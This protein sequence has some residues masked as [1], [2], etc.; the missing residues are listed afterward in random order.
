MKKPALKKEEFE[1]ELQELRNNQS[2]EEDEEEDGL[3]KPSSQVIDI[4]DDEVYDAEEEDELENLADTSGLLDPKISDKQKH[5]SRKQQLQQQKMQLYRQNRT[6]FILFIALCIGI[7]IIFLAFFLLWPRETGNNPNIW[8]EAV[9]APIL[10]T[11]IPWAM[12]F[13]LTDEPDLSCLKTFVQSNQSSLLTISKQKQHTSKLYISHFG[14]EKMDQSGLIKQICNKNVDK[15]PADAN[16]TSILSANWPNKEA[17]NKVL[18]QYLS[19]VPSYSTLYKQACLEKSYSIGEYFSKALQVFS[20]VPSWN[21]DASVYQQ[22]TDEHQLLKPVQIS[23]LDSIFAKQTYILRCITAKDKHFKE[24]IL[25]QVLFFV[26][27]NTGAVEKYPTTLY[28]TMYKTLQ[29]TSCGSSE[30]LI[31]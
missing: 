9:S 27:E 6:L 19:D 30:I 2:D 7:A 29:V 16:L 4:E 18:S 31:P 5:R 17:D 10:R 1:R 25:Q 12:C 23:T 15:N 24:P 11:W 28:E 20:K 26:N 14:I 8:T 13:A 22:I 21:F 3:H